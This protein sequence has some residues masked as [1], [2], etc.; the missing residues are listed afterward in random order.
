MLI[1]EDFGKAETDGR[2]LRTSNRAPWREGGALQAFLPV[3]VSGLTFVKNWQC[4]DDIVFSAD[5]QNARGG[6]KRLGLNL[7]AVDHYHPTL[8]PVYL[9]IDN[10][11]VFQDGKFCGPIVWAPVQETVVMLRNHFDQDLHREKPSLRA[12]RIKAEKKTFGKITHEH[13][14]GVRVAFPWPCDRRRGYG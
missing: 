4:F 13:P 7:V 5:R 2:N 11:A 1:C 14:A 9:T 8:V 6:E 3:P 10:H 12:Q